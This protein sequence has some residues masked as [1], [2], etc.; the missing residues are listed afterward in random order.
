MSSGSC[1]AQGHFNMWPGGTRDWTTH[2]FHFVNDPFYLLSH[3]RA[4]HSFTSLHTWPTTIWRLIVFDLISW[5]VSHWWRCFL[6]LQQLCVYV[7]RCSRALSSQGHCRCEW[8]KEQFTV[9]KRHLE[10]MCFK[11]FNPQNI[12]KRVVKETCGWNATSVLSLL[13]ICW[14][15]YT[16]TYIVC[17]SHVC[18]LLYIH[19]Y[20]HN[21]N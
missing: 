18:Y 2:L 15:E 14:T 17:A 21:T 16:H 13:N 4:R 10:T 20:F 12:S 19:E 6:H 8:V 7:C 3:S 11:C 5:C 1:L 9:W